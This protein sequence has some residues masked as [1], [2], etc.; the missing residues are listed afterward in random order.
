MGW[1]SGNGK[2][3]R[4]EKMVLRTGMGSEDWKGVVRNGKK[5]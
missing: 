2:V 4:S 1:C 3:L 5:F